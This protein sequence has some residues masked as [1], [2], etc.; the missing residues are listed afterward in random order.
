MYHFVEPPS[1]VRNLRYSEASLSAD[2]VILSWE[3]PE[4]LGHR[5]DLFYTVE[6]DRCSAL[7]IYSP[8]QSE[9][10]TNSVTLKNLVPETTYTVSI[11]AENGVSASARD[12]GSRTTTRFTTLKSGATPQTA[13]EKVRLLALSGNLATVR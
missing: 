9:F 6:C 13:P 1:A 4:Y 11:L 12:A 7:V 3:T 5:S 8:K 2:S 10:T